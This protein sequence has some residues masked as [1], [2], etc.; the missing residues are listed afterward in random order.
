MLNLQLL[1]RHRFVF[2]QT[3]AVLLL[4]LMTGCGGSAGARAGA[5]PNGSQNAAPTT[6]SVSIMEPGPNSTVG[7]PINVQA[8]VTDPNP[9]HVTQIYVDGVKK[10]EQLGAGISAQLN[11]TDGSHKLTVQAVQTDSTVVKTSIQINVLNAVGTGQE[12]IPPSS[13]VVLV[14]EENHSYSQVLSSMPWLVSMGKTYGHALNYHADTPGSLLDYLWLSSG[15]GELTFGCNGAGCSKPIT[16]NNI[17]RELN[18]AGLSWKVYAQNLPYA[19]YMGSQSGAY[20]KRHNPAAWYSDIIS[21]ATQQKKMVPFSQLATDLANGT[22]PR[23]SIIVPDLNHDAH[24]GTLGA[25]DDFLKNSVSGVL[26]YPAF[27][28]D[29]LMIVTFD[30]CDAAVGACSELV[31]TALIGPNVRRA[32]TSSTSYRHESTLRTILDAFGI[33]TF[34]GAANSTKPMADFF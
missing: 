9:V 2:Q 5:L 24:D 31:Y 16:D 28:K 22:L 29:G 10:T 12:G 7:S 25:A 17:F 32:S 30:E 14:I 4:V 18:K 1:G 20:V 34:P 21:S 11:L 27:R 3:F 6:A 13:H 19:G 8:T 26:N 15:S 33:K 23:Y